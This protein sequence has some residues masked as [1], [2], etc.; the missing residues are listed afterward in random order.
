VLFFIGMQDAIRSA[1][2]VAVVLIGIPVYYF[3]FQR[4]RKV[5]G[6]DQDYSVD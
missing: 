3:V 5:N 6:L 2:G 4:R 1:A